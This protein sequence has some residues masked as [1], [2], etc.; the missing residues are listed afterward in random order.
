MPNQYYYTTKAPFLQYFAVNF[1]IC[2]YKN[3]RFQST[4]PDRIFMKFSFIF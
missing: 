3:R 1:S 4:V 2:F